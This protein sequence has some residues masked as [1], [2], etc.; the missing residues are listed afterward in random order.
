MGDLVR[1]SET[2]QQILHTRK[3]LQLKALRIRLAEKTNILEGISGRIAQLRNVEIPRLELEQDIAHVEV[4]HLK[5]EIR[6]VAREVGG[7]A[8]EAI[9][10]EFTVNED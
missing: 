5:E 4:E 1:R 9:D 3:D 2:A 10:A 6:G 7:D 8:E